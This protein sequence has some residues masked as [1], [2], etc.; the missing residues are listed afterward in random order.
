LI[1]NARRV[2]EYLRRRLGELSNRHAHIGEVRGAGLYVG[3]DVVAPEG[4]SGEVSP[5]PDLAQVLI[6][7]LR[8]R[9]V[10]IGAAGKFGHVLKIRPPL[11]FATADADILVD[12][13]DDVLH[14]LPGPR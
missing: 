1:A 14:H 2:G 7:G 12:A 8:E 3:V 4:R 5:A 6:N 11:C 10:L 13:L 9:R